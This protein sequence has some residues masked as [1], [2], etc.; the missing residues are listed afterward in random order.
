LLR[1]N[2]EWTLHNHSYFCP[3]SCFISLYSFINITFDDL[4]LI[5]SKFLIDSC[6]LIAL[7]PY[8]NYLQPRRLIYQ[9]YKKEF[10]KFFLLKRISFI[11]AVQ[12]IHL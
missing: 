1:I 11:L 2:V 4:S 12:S 7:P 6:D 8:T 10:E 9:G 3:K 5:S